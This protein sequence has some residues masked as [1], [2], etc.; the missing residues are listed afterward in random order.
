MNEKKARALRKMT[1]Y[2]PADDPIC[3]RKY[4]T[5]VAEKNVAVGKRKRMIRTGHVLAC[6]GQRLYYRLAKQRYREGAF[7]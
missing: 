7:R 4:A 5:L 2:N 3:E 1:G 6:K